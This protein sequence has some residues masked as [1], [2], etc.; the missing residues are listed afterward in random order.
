MHYDLITEP[1]FT[2]DVKKAKKKVRDLNKMFNLV[3]MLCE[4]DQL[5]PKYRDH[6]LYDSSDLKNV[7]E[8]HILEDWLLIYRKEENTVRLIR[9]GT[10]DELF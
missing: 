8:C 5:P 9:T 4:G 10:H 7:R 3:R 2:R 6:K 1:Q